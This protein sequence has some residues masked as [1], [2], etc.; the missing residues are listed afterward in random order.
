[1]IRAIAT[2][3]LTLSV[4]ALALPP[5]SAALLVPAAVASVDVALL[6][7][8]VR[9]GGVK[10][11]VGDVAMSVARPGSWVPSVAVVTAPL[12]QQTFAWW[13]PLA[14]LALT[15]VTAVERYVVH[16]LCHTVP[17]LW[18]VHEVHHRPDRVSVLTRSWADP[19]DPSLWSWAPLVAL[20]FGVPPQVVAASQL[21][22]LT[23]ATQHCGAPLAEPRWP[24]LFTSHHHRHHAN[25]G[26]P[27]NLALWSTWPDW[28]GGTLR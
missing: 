8:E 14:V 18:R 19:L 26:Q 3:S 4:L 22:M 17:A 21:A 2:A 23:A 25:G 7:A 1:M 27:V 24:L 6:V 9:H 28:L 10:R 15:L 11:T 13:W 16:R 20:A 12:A 5:V